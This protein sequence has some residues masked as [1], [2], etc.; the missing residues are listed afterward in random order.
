MDRTIKITHHGDTYTF[1]ESDHVHKLNGKPLNGVTTIIKQTV[2]K[3]ALITWYMN[4]AVD[5]IAENCS[6]APTKEQLKAAKGEPTAVMQRAAKW[7]TR[8]HHACEKWAKTGELPL[9]DEDIYKSVVNFTQFIQNNGFRIVEVE[10]NVW[11]K[12]L[13][14]GGI[15]DLVLEKNGKYYIAD[16]KTSSGIYDDYFIQMGAYTK[17][18]ME[19]DILTEYGVESITGA[20]IINL[21]KDGKICWASSEAV[22]VME[23]AFRNTLDLFRAR[24]VLTSVAKSLK[25]G[26]HFSN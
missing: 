25:L 15:L 9:P 6:E 8:V 24:D 18:M 1:D 4:T 20:I 16:I 23:Q 13:W 14:I 3:P 5:Y 10:R 12:E 17:C 11:S 7:G 2:A 21:K 22:E 26:W 19:L